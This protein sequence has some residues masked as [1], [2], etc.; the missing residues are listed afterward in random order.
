MTH[1][2]ED[3]EEV[4][5]D[6]SNTEAFSSTSFRDQE[7]S[8]TA[9]TQIA[10]RENRAVSWSRVLVFAV[11]AISAAAT[12]LMAYMLLSKEEQNTFEKEVSELQ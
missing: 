5:E 8:T 11:L 4:P 1:R 12:A 3:D 2:M 6:D 7:S 10:A 9:S